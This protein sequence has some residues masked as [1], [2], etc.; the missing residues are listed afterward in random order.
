[1]ATP[2]LVLTLTP[3]R[4]LRH[5]RWAM[6]LLAM[7]A[8]LLA[9]LPTWA[10]AGLLASIAASLLATVRQR[11]TPLTMRLET[12]GTLRIRVGEHW[13]AVAVLPDSVVLPWLTVL[14][15]RHGQGPVK[16]WVILADA[17]PADAFRRLRIWLRWR[18]VMGESRR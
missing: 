16:S 7:P 2:P 5:A 12:E 1:M 6:H 8:V 10:Q 3:S 18:A 11:M 15:Y 14:R 13:E 17:L 9:D 4:R